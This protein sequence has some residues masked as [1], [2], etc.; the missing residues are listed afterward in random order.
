MPASAV[1]VEDH[2]GEAQEIISRCRAR[3]TVASVLV[4]PGFLF[5]EEAAGTEKK[6]RELNDYE[7]ANRLSYLLWSTL[8]DAE[9]TKL[10]DQKKLGEPSVLRTQV[11]RMLAAPPSRQFVENFVGQWMKVREFDS[12]MVDTASTLMPTMYALRYA[13]LREPYEALHELLRADLPAL[14]PRLTAISSSST[15]GWRNTTAWTASRASP[16]SG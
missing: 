1:Y 15:S 10:A 6:A 7:L 13:S 11:K 8:P 14:E 9:L 4:S 12:V 16:S 3:A 2:A 5:L